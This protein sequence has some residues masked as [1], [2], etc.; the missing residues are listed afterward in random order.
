MTSLLLV[1]QNLHRLQFKKQWILQRR[2]KLVIGQ[3]LNIATSMQMTLALLGPH[4][5]FV[6][7][8]GGFTNTYT[9][10]TKCNWV[11][12]TSPK[13]D[14]LQQSSLISLSLHQQLR[15]GCFCCLVL[16]RR[17]EFQSLVW[18]FTLNDHW[19]PSS[20]SISIT[21]GWCNINIIS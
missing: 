19:V 11:V 7:G 4:T 16:L 9:S 1:I 6:W 12:V 14:F 8:L 13:R 10:S 20:I 5:V 2:P 18:Q 17:S 3:W 21:W 15:D